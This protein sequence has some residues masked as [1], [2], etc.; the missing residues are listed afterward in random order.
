[1]NAV[2]LN[3]YLLAAVQGDWNCIV[4]YDKCGNYKCVILWSC[5]Q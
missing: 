3:L 5:P 2:T 1:M 4:N